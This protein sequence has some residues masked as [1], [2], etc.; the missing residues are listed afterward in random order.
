L[1]ASHPTVSAEIFGQ[2]KR[3]AI[4][5]KPCIS[6]YDGEKVEFTDG[7]RVRADLV[8]LATGYKVVFPFLAP[9]VLSAPGNQV[10][11]YLNIF[12]P[13]YDDLGVL[14]LVQTVGSNIR[15]AWAQAQ[16]VGDWVAGKYALPSSEEMRAA[17]AEHTRALRERYVA[18]P[19]HTLQVDHHDYLRLVEAELPR[20]DRRSSCGVGD[21]EQQHR[22]VQAVQAMACGRDAHMRTGVQLQ[23]L[24]AHRQAHPP[25]QDLQGGG[26]RAAV[27]GE[28]HP[29]VESDERLLQGQPRPG[30][31]G[32]CGTAV[33]GSAGG[34]EQLLGEGGDVHGVGE[35]GG[36]DVGDGHCVLLIH[37]GVMDSE[38]VAIRPPPWPGSGGPP[39]NVR[40][41]DPHAGGGRR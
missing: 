1:G 33:A 15:M 38:G 40:W 23:V 19:R 20:A 3:G 35:P 2:L 12:D 21:G 14:G 10:E 11:L 5:V 6:R 26:T 29:L 8:V 22:L 7:S 17:I 13:R 37:V 36:C 31:Q 39:T 30:C 32:P 25:P 34:G 41:R 4:T 9:E 28:G 24:L 27:L 18:S 16:L